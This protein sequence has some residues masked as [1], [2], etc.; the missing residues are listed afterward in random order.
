MRATNRSVLDHFR[1][2]TGDTLIRLSGFDAPFFRACRV[3]VVEKGVFWY[4]M[5]PSLIADRE[6]ATSR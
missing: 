6:G 2:H 1:G 3:E 5:L 4:V